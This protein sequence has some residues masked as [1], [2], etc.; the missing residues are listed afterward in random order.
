MKNMCLSLPKLKCRTQYE[1]R[2]SDER[3][4]TC[5]MQETN[6][7]GINSF[8]VKTAWILDDGTRTEIFLLKSLEQILKRR[9]LQEP[10]FAYVVV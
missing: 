5:W 2:I 4:R 3:Q 1:A 10:E 9:V 7:Y 6:C 8:G